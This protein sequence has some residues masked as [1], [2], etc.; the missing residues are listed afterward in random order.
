MKDF[1]HDL[2]SCL[3]E[4]NPV[5]LVALGYLSYIFVGFILLSLPF[6]HTKYVNALDNLFIATSA[7]STTGLTTVSVSDVYNFWGQLV[8]LILIQLGG[9]GYMTF[10]SFVILST[11][12]YLDERTKNVAQVVFSIPK[13][14]KI[15]KF[16][17]SVIVFSSIVE[18][19]GAVGLYFVFLQADIA[20]PLWNAIFHSV[21]AFCT[22]GFSLFSDSFEGMANNA[23]LN[24][25]ISILSIMGAM[26]FIVC[27]DIW[28][29]IRGKV[30]HMTLTTKV[31]ISM[32][33]WLLI[34][35]G[36]LMFLTENYGGGL[37][38]ENKILLSLFQSMTALTTVGFNTVTI[39]TLSKSAIMLICILMIIGAS[40]SGTGGGLKTTTFSAIWGLMRSTI[41]GDRDVRIF[42]AIVP[43]DRV[44]TAVATFSFYTFTLIAGTYIL[45]MTENGMF[46]EIFFEAA[47]ALGT[48]GLSMG[49]TSA[50]TVLGKLIVIMLMYIGRVGP[51]TFGM[52]LYVKS[53][54]IF[55]NEKTDL[56]I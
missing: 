49:I 14:F 53:E 3:K 13:N 1:F 50:L 32:T 19:F 35:G 38:P 5:R 40:P 54:L 52:A 7:V 18:I 55:D 12:K 42:G 44:K 8:T 36:S 51:L 4:I 10:S 48:V 30:R 16:I 34:I 23:G 39:S 33:L 37:S 41:K 45:T 31:I 43:E 25:I 24:V 28:R 29:L 20:N 9:I 27:V 17:L 2:I 15:E 47:S 46:I 56:A 22:A 11:K 26:G 21:S 6:M